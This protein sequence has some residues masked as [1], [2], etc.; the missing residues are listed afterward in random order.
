MNDCER[1][2]MTDKRLLTKDGCEV[3][4]VGLG[5]FP[6]Q[7]EVMAE[8]VCAAFKCGYRLFDTADDY[9][10]EPGIGLALTRLAEDGIGRE[11]LFLQT[12]ISDDSAHSDDPL[13]GMYFNANSDF[14]RRHSVGEIV[15]EKVTR[16]LRMMGTDYLDS[17]L[18]HYPYPGY[19]CD[20]WKELVTLKGEG[21]IR[22][23]GVS[24]FRVRHMENLIRETGVNPDIN[25]LYLSPLSVKADEVRFCH[26][27]SCVPMAYS[28]LMDLAAGRLSGT[29]LQ[30]IAEARDKS[31]AQIVLRWNIERGCFV[32]PKTK[33][34]ERLCENFKVFDFSL[35]DKEVAGISA[36]NQDYQY[37]V[38]SRICPGV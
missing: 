23:I 6:F 34:T 28:P 20:I 36:L 5:T 26:E 30:E 37:C 21:K 13:S 12:K 32:L 1:L 9:R 27:H 31:V 10:G 11:Q 17:V 19:Y 33:S 38:E 8:A 15:R 2:A 16:S 22:Y 25:E 14:M 35:T 3:P 18:I 4:M 24:N 29:A 7:G